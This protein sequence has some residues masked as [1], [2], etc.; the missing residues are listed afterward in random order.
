M[1]ANQLVIRKLGLPGCSVVKNLLARPGD[2]GSIL[3]VGR[4][5]NPLRCSRLRNP[6]DRDWWATWGRRQSDR[7]EQLNDRNNKCI[8]TM[9][10]QIRGLELIN[11][12]GYLILDIISVGNLLSTCLWRV[13]CKFQYKIWYP[14]PKPPKLIITVTVS[15]F[16]DLIKSLSLEI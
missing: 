16:L 14:S 5:C 12:A 3:G 10:N 11:Y 8:Q 15:P 2:T 7:T 6:V 4:R 9:G 1:S 13:V